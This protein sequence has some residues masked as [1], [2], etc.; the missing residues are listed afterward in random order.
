MR[1]DRERLLD[2]LDAIDLIQEETTGGRA[3]FD[4]DRKLR[5]WV[6][7]HIQVIGEASAK[8]SDDL[9]AAHTDVPWQRIRGMRN[10]LVHGYFDVEDDVVWSVVTEDLEPLRAHVM[11]M[12]DRLSP[13]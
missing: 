6:L 10:I 2:I 5:I 4:G 8:L 3:A 9:R 7:H 1:T 11:T 13:D 12:L